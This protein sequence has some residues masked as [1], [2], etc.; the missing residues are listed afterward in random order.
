[1]T[2]RNDALVVK[3]NE[4][5]NLKTEGDFIKVVTNSYNKKSSIPNSIILLI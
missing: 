1:M 5:L 4:F 3:N 2:F